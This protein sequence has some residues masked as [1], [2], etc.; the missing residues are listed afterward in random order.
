MNF[1]KKTICLIWIISMC[2]SMGCTSGIEKWVG[3]K[4]Y[5]F[6]PDFRETQIMGHILQ[7]NKIVINP[8]IANRSISMPL[9]EKAQLHTI[10]G[11]AN[12]KRLLQEVTKTPIMGDFF[13][14]QQ[15][16]LTLRDLSTEKLTE[17]IPT[18]PCNNFKMKMIT[19]ILNAG[20]MSV[21]IKDA[22]GNDITY[23]FKP[24]SETAVPNDVVFGRPIFITGR[25]FHLGFKTETIDCKSINRK[26][27]LIN[28]D[29]TVNDADVALQLRYMDHRRQGYENIALIR[30]MVSG[31]IPEDQTDVNTIKS[32]QFFDVTDPEQTWEAA[33]KPQNGR[34]ELT[35]GG[36]VQVFEGV[37]GGLAAKT[38]SSGIYFEVL[39]ITERAVQMRIQYISYLTQ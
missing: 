27:I 8:C 21:V 31:F 14:A 20:G 38:R 35:Q 25:Q 3:Q 1:F 22:G 2:L 24:V 10:E 30:I 16:I 9:S 32:N 6:D 12:I 26:D 37:R 33:H 28:R 36:I 19:E 7:D 4:G 17:F 11:S 13:Q 23:L 29:Q 15:A 5:V 39:S 34:L 18:G